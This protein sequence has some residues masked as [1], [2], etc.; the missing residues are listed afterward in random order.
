MVK[1]IIVQRQ[2]MMAAW[3]RVVATGV[4]IVK[5]QV[6]GK[7]GMEASDVGDVT[8]VSAGATGAGNSEGAGLGKI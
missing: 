6:E 5:G 1:D 4:E 8:A 3:T 2:E 7:R